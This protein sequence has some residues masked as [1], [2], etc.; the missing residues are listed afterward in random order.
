M[1]G[2]SGN[3]KRLQPAVPVPKALPVA[4]V[5]VLSVSFPLSAVVAVWPAERNSLA[6][7]GN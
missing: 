3:I 5:V 7:A 4:A 2:N 6:A 1:G